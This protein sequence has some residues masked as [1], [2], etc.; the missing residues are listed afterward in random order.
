MST[1]QSSA[2]KKKPSSSTSQLRSPIALRETRTKKRTFDPSDFNVPPRKKLNSKTHSSKPMGEDDVDGEEPFGEDSQSYKSDDS[3]S[4]AGDSD[5]SSMNKDDSSGVESGGDDGVDDPSTS[6]SESS[7]GEFDEMMKVPPTPPPTKPKPSAKQLP[8]IA[9][10]KNTSRKPSASKKVSPPPKQSPRSVPTSKKFDMPKWLTNEM[11]LDSSKHAHFVKVENITH[12]SDLIELDKKALETVFYNSAKSVGTVAVKSQVRLQV[13]RTAATMFTKFIGRPLDAQSMSWDDCLAHFQEEYQSILQRCEEESQAFPKLG[14]STEPN[15]YID[16]V[17]L[18]AAHKFGQGKIPLSYLLREDS[19]P[20]SPPPLA[21]GCCHS[22]EY[23]SLADELVAF[24]PHSGVAF[25]ED[26]KT[27]AKELENSIRTTVYHAHVKQLLK[28]GKGSAAWSSLLSHLAGKIYYEDRITTARNFIQNTKWSHASKFSLKQFVTKFKNAHETMKECKDAGHSVAVFDER[29]LVRLFLAAIQVGNTDPL[30]AAS[31]STIRQDL[32]GELSSFKLTT[33]HL[34]ENVPDKSRGG[35]RKS[36]DPSASISA[37]G[38]KGNQ[39]R[40]G[41]KSGSGGGKQ[42]KGK[43]KG[44]PSYAGGAL[45]V[46]IG[47][48]GVHLRWHTPNEMKNLT[49]EQLDELRKYFTSAQQSSQ[50]LRKNNETLKATVAAMKGTTGDSADDAPTV[51]AP[52][53]ADG[54][55]GSNLAKIA[56]TLANLVSELQTT[57]PSRKKARVSSATVQAVGE[58]IVDDDEEDAYSPSGEEFEEGSSDG[59]SVSSAAKRAMQQLVTRAPILAKKN[60]PSSP[61]KRKRQSRSPRS[62]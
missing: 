58:D 3:K 17:Q 9:V 26:E 60:R 11:L 47:K 20:G 32:K 49:K 46:G 34:L 22:D 24:A 59:E 33:E 10:T 54:E 5:P 42:G 18:W 14:Q 51:N 27:F 30:L 29:E 44:S 57:P 1:V 6:G 41:Q 40:R 23:E 52:A 56:S 50:S 12:P 55:K 4:D 13:A 19:N 45:K 28:K 15:T 8:T 21:P 37:V 39:S 2:P 48:T 25:R 36:D 53:P 43:G 7:D 31:I 16:G 38:G 61:K 62:T 35:R